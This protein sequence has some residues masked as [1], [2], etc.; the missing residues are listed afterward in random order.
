MVDCLKHVGNI[1]V[2]RKM[3]NIL[4][5]SASWSVLAYRTGPAAFLEFTLLNFYLTLYS[6]LLNVFSSL[7]L[8]ACMLLVALLSLLMLF[9]LLVAAL[10]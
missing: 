6:V 4:K 1:D 7:S 9:A 2:S 10:K 3:L 8:S 5:T